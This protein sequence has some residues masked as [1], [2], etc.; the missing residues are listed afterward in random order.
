MADEILWEKRDRIRILT[1]NRPD[2]LNALS[3][4][5]M[6]REAECLDEF[7]TDDDAWV[8]IYTGTGRAFST[9]LDLGAA[10]EILAVPPEKRPRILTAPNAPEIWKPII[11]AVNGYALGGGC[12]LA[13]ACDI[14]VAAD[15]ASF[16]LPEVKR[17][18]IPGAGGCQRLPRLIGLGNAFLMLLTGERID[19]GEAYRVGLVQKVVPRETLLDETFALAEKICENGPVAVRLLKEAALRGAEMSLRDAL[20]QDRLMSIRNRQTAP[21]DVEEGI[22]AF[23]EKRKPAYKGR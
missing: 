7:Q 21:E 22:K 2:A 18:L 13:L 17:A 3:L 23:R 16:G 14:R 1:L 11:A 5:M 4:P 6:R 12:E 9:G 15:D 8:L 19:A 20:A 10:R